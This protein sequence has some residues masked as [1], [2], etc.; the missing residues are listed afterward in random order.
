MALRQ[1]INDLLEQPNENLEI[2]KHEWARFRSFENFPMAS[3]M[4]P[5]KL[6]QSGFYYLGHGEEVKCAFCGLTLSA[7]QRHVSIH[8]THNRLSP[9]CRFVN[10]QT[11]SNV[12]I[13]HGE[14]ENPATEVSHSC[15]Q[16]SQAARDT[17][18]GHSSG[19][20][21]PTA[22]RY[23]FTNMSKYTQYASREARILTFQLWGYN[24]IVTPDDLADAGLFHT[25]EDD[26]VRCYHCGGG[27]KNWEPGDHPL[28]EHANWFPHCEFIKMKSAALA[29]SGGQNGSS[30][31]ADETRHQKAS[32]SECLRTSD[33][34][35]NT[36]LEQHSNTRSEQHNNPR[37]DQ[38]SNILSEQ[39]SNTQSEHRNPRSEHHSSPRPEHHSNPRSEHHSSPQPEHHSNQ[40]SEHHSSP[41]PEHHNN[42]RSE[43]HSNLRSEQHSNLRSEHHNNT[44]SEHNDSRLYELN[45]ITRSELNSSQSD[46]NNTQSE[47]A[48]TRNKKP[49]HRGV[50]KEND[51]LKQQMMCKI[52]MDKDATIVFLPCGHMVAC[53][54]CAHALRKCPICRHVIKGAVRAFKT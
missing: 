16:E 46:H 52:C 51:A 47:Q 36:R 3:S 31:D 50:Q 14:P 34:H 13:L 30:S 43:H 12:P 53:V 40:R 22:E 28:T 18:S 5:L 39:H 6:A 49:C 19:A 24:P 27:M 44:P 11:F 23:S 35:N 33:R 42:P 9:G 48:S 4:S 10:G 7:T 26:C 8:E 2:M 25:G 37:S 38:Y 21:D 45:E 17:T 32:T 15:T 20:L 41:R 29:R 1:Y 54:D